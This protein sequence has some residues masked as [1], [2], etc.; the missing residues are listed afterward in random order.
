[1]RYA[2]RFSAEKL[3]TCQRRSLNHSGVGNG[4][5]VPWPKECG[6]LEDANGGF[7]VLKNFLT[8]GGFLEER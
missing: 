4:P 5:L 3:M 2:S 1:M 6:M 7:T 8:K